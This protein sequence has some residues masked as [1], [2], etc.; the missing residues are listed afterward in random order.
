MLE[1]LIE[2]GPAEIV[3]LVL[4]KVESKQRRLT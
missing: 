3:V 2:L 4:I 1:K